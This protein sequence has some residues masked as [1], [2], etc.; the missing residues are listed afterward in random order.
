MNAMKA[1]GVAGY[2]SVTTY[3][4]NPKSVAMDNLYGY[5][6]YDTREW[7]DGILASVLRVVSF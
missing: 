7:I 1:D 5:Y 3:V 4:L 2:E 6:H